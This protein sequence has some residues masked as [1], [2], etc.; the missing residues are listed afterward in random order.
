MES[1]K[2]NVDFIEAESN[3]VVTRPEAGKV[4]VR[5]MRRGYDEMI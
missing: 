5:E 2:K 4:G 3:K 1:K